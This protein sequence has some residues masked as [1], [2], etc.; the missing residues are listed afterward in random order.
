MRRPLP[1]LLL[2]FLTL[3]AT[4]FAGEGDP[5]QP[6]DT[7]GL[8][9]FQAGGTAADELT[10]AYRSL[11]LAFARVGAERS[12][13]IEEAAKFE[14]ATLQAEPKK[15]FERLSAADSRLFE[16]IAISNPRSLLALS[17]FYED[18]AYRHTSD[19][20]WGLAL[21][22]HNSTEEILRRLAGAAESEDDR[23]VASAAYQSFAADLLDN[24]APGRAMEALEQ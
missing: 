18:L 14:R 21:R 16:A 9:P 8:V 11:Y 2:S 6:S 5:I 1:L 22:A 19:R 7:Q 12:T 15:G 4:S 3:A 20:N 17:L 23:A 13:T 10:A 24:V